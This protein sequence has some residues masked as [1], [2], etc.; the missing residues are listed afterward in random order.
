MISYFYFKSAFPPV[1]S[2]LC[3]DVSTKDRE[4]SASLYFGVFLSSF[5]QT[6]YF[7]YELCNVVHKYVMYKFARNE[8]KKSKETKNNI[9]NITIERGIK[10]TP[11]ATSSK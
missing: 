8:S 10:I 9:R 5:P 7:C 4:I 11:N 2:T 1:L 6:V 3:A